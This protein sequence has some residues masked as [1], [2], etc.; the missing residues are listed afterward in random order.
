[1]RFLPFNPCS[2]LK[3]FK[4]IML[5]VV[6]FCWPRD[7]N[8]I[9]IG[10]WCGELYIDNPKY[11]LDYLLEHT[12]FK[13]VWVGKEHV[14]E[15]LPKHERLKFA[16]KDSF[17]AFW[18]LLNAKTWVCCQ[19]INID[20]TTL[21]IL[22]RAVCID[23]WH[24]IP[25]KF[26]GEQTPKI[27]NSRLSL[28]ALKR[29]CHKVIY[30]WKSWIVVSNSRMVDLLC[31]GVPE[32]Y[33]KQRVLLIGTPRN[34]FLINHANDEKL[35]EKLRDKYSALLGFE[36][37]KKIVLYLP[38]WRM[39]G[40]EVFTFYNQTVALQ[41]R[42][43]RLLDEK[44]AVL[45]EKHHWG[46][47][48]RYPST[49]SSLCSIAISASQQKQIDI[50]EL[51]L[52]ADMLISDYSG[53]Y[54]DFA[55]LQRPVVHF[56]YDLEKYTNEDS[57][58]AYSLQDVAAGPIVLDVNELESVVNELLKRESFSPA[59]GYPQL[60]EYEQGTSSSKIVEFINSRSRNCYACR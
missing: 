18:N 37:E 42:W 51:L 8:L 31:D 12:E 15:Q 36:N 30:D 3:I 58:L 17:A 20:L 52:I 21:P 5:R 7:R 44:N 46:T 47:Y 59:N 33:N 32:R 27:R 6:A 19:A 16:A 25:I 34:D 57:G 50:Q 13:V 24:G 2:I 1:M 4:H 43:K 38:T 28:S 10:G 22:G 45:I 26:I 54:I 49:E 35:K 60:V 53:A 9:V 56:A 41:D 14:R 39:S 40:D 29:L 48:A 55:L 11:L 23:L